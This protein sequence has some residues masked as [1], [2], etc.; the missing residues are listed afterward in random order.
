MDV[1][2]GNLLSCSLTVRLEDIDPFRVQ[3]LFHSFHHVPDSSE[4]ILC[5]SPF[6]VGERLRVLFRHHES[7]PSAHRVDIQEGEGCVVLI[8]HVR[9]QLSLDYLAERAF[10]VW[11]I[12]TGIVG[13]FNQSSDR[14]EAVL[15]IGLGY[16]H[17]M[18]EELKEA[19]EEKG[20]VMIRTESGEN[21]ELHKHNVNFIGDGMIRIDADEETHWFDAEKVERYWIHED[22]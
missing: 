14:A 22:F 12:V 7:V 13:E 5:I 9:V 21:H 4:E 18:Y 2:V 16:N 20:E 6:E 8:D 15:K 3:A 17:V 11:H 1:N 10:S 19:V